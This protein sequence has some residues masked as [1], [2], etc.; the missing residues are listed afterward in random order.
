MIQLYKDLHLII[1]K[2]LSDYDKVK[3]MATCKLLNSYKNLVQYTE[4][5]NYN[6][7]KHWHSF[8]VFKKILFVACSDDI[9]DYAT[10]LF[11]I[12]I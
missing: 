1:I 3:I 6:K 5:Y 7:I 12:V 4:V 9:P 8:L 10:H 11:Y 2:F